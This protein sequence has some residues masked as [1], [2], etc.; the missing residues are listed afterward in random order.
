MKD[1][2]FDLAERLARELRAGEVL[3]C[4]LSGERSDF[5]RFNRGRVRQAGTVEQCSV[6]VRLVRERRHAAAT[7]A[8]AGNG[9]DLECAREAIAGLREALADLPED[10]WLSIAEEPRSTS[11]ERRGTLAD[12]QAVVDQTLAAAQGRDLVGIYAGGPVYRGFANSLGQR[13]WHEVESFHFDWSLHGERDRAVKGSHA[14][15]E[16]DP[17]VLGASWKPRPVSSCC[18]GPG[19]AASSPVNTALTSPRGRSRS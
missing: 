10:P 16:W 5:V 18:S 4:N 19:R 11:S 7:L 14:G 6:S 8:L 1:R 2:F 3:L 15:F 17:A 13:N 9:E 12:A